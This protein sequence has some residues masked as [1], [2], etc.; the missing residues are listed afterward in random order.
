MDGPIAEVKSNLKYLR[1]LARDFPTQAAAAS[2]VIRLEATLKLPK[3]TE[4]YISDLHGE[5][6]AFIHIL[7]SASG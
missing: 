1:L 5:D 3:G 2:E 4:H 7:N 6:E